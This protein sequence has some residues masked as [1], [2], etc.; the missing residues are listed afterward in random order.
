MLIARRIYPTVAETAVAQAKKLHRT[1]EG[2]LDMVEWDTLICGVIGHTK[3]WQAS[4]RAA[5]TCRRCKRAFG[6][7]RL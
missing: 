4:A 6:G 5:F 3:P 2:W 1:I 7:V